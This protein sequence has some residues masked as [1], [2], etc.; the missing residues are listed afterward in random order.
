MI[1]LNFISLPRWTCWILVIKV[2]SFDQILCDRFVCMLDQVIAMFFTSMSC[3][4][5]WV[6]L[7]L[8]LSPLSHL[9][10]IVMPLLSLAFRL[11]LRSFSPLSLFLLFVSP[12]ALCSHS[13]TVPFGRIVRG[14]CCRLLLKSFRTVCSQQIISRE[15]RGKIS[16]SIDQSIIEYLSLFKSNLLFLFPS[17]L[18]FIFLSQ[19]P[20]CQT[21]WCT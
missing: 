21:I 1:L 3:P 10:L 11:Y 13:L 12:I 18:I 20:R 7:C 5:C 4:V 2:E 19:K 8:S 15:Y 9:S 16:Y 6:C 14:C 17:K